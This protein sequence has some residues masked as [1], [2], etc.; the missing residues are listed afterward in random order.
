MFLQ[1]LTPKG[2]PVYL[3]PELV[4]SLA[5]YHTTHEGRPWLATRITLTTRE[6]LYVRGDVDAIK[7]A[8]EAWHEANTPKWVVSPGQPVD[9]QPFSLSADQTPAGC[10][11]VT[12]CLLRNSVNPDTRD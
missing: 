10:P 4:A 9:I 7:D 6:D 3:R 11:D 5:G 1:F 2:N 12:D 8:V